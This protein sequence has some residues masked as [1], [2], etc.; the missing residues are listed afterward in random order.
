MSL[1]STHRYFAVVA[2]CRKN[3]R[4]YLFIFSVALLMVWLKKI[5]KNFVIWFFFRSILFFTTMKFIIT[6]H[7]RLQVVMI[8]VCNAFLFTFFFITM[9]VHLISFY[10]FYLFLS[11][12]FCTSFWNS[13]LCRRHHRCCRSWISSFVLVTSYS[14]DWIQCKWCDRRANIHQRD[15][16]YNRSTYII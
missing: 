5:Y 12:I 16:K 11:I 15:K 9:I 4:F 6:I 7:T 1:F 2:H 13:Q 10:C 3:S 14:I 8:S